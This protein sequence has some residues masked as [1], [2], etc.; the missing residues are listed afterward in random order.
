MKQE[1]TLVRLNNNLLMLGHAFSCFSVL[2]SQNVNL[3]SGSLYK[4]PHQVSVM[5]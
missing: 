1:T 5:M 3:S 4:V 2:T